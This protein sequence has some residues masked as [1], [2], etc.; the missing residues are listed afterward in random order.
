[1]DAKVQDGEISRILSGAID[2]QTNKQKYQENKQNSA[3][4]HREHN[5]EIIRGESERF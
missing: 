4:T 1:M 5:K 2:K 3:L